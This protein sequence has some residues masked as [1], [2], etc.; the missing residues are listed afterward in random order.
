MT[1]FSY[2]LYSSRNFPPLSD[3]LTMLGKLGY[4]S[5]EGYGA[6][7]AEPEKVAELK[8]HLS[9][10]G[11]TMPTGH[12]GLDML[13]KEP[14]RVLAIAGDLGIETIYCPFIMPNQRPDTGKGYEDLGRRLQAASKP[15]RDAGLGFG[16]HNHAFE[17]IALDD[18]ALPQAAIFEGGS[19]LEWE[20]DIAWVIKGGADPFHFIGLWGDRITA[21][22]VKDIA[23][24]GENADEDGWA[25]VGHGTVDWPRLMVALAGAKVRHFIMEHD[26]PNDAARF[27]SR[28]IAAAKSF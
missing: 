7:Y 26:N 6:L 27:A 21:V 22:H 20:A 3:T 1:D 11:L 12:F 5:V 18:G 19:D 14:G 16:W 10:A 15:F 2:Q 13:E 4:K 24:E 25:D 23:P 17:F 28:S 9:A 8:Q